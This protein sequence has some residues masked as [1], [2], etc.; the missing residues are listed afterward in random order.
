[1]KAPLMS[2]HKFFGLRPGFGV[3]TLDGLSDMV[4]IYAPAYYDIRQCW[5]VARDNPY[6]QEQ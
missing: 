2:P 1:M 6:Y 5:L 3:L 4:P